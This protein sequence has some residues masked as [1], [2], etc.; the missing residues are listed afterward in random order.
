MQHMYRFWGLGREPIW[1]GGRGG[2]GIILP[3]T[4]TL[5]FIVKYIQISAG[6]SSL[7]PLTKIHEH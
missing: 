4:V 5:T 6:N 7:T 1:G 2:G 3:N